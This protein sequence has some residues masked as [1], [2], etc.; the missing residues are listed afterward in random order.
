M[1]FIRKNKIYHSLQA[2]SAHQEVCRMYFQSE[3]EGYE[4]G[5]ALVPKSSDDLLC[6]KLKSISCPK[7]LIL[8]KLCKESTHGTIYVKE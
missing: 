3:V 5:C 8:V 7:Q 2:S 4:D 1:K 6:K